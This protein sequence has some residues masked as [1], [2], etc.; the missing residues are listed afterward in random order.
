MTAI[1]KLEIW[2]KFVYDYIRKKIA[3]NV[4]K[5]SDEEEHL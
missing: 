4:Q 3:K 2:L 5:E 1:F